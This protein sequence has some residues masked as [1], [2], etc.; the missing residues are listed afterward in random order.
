MSQDHHFLPRPRPR[1]PDSSQG[2]SRRSSGGHVGALASAAVAVF[3]AA[4]AAAVLLTVGIRPQ[5]LT[6]LY[7]GGRGG[8]FPCGGPSG[9]GRFSSP[10]RSARS[11]APRL[12]SPSTAATSPRAP[13]A[14]PHPDHDQDLRGGRG[15][16]A[17]RGGHPRD[18]P[19]WP[20]GHLGGANPGRY[21]RR[22]RGDG[23]RV[24]GGQ[25]HAIGLGPALG[26]LLDTFGVRT[27]LVPSIVVLL[28]RW[29][30]WPSRPGKQPARRVMSRRQLPRQGISFAGTTED[31]D[32]P[33]A[34]PGQRRVR[35]FLAWRNPARPIKGTWIAGRLRANHLGR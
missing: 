7:A 12:P 28:G 16:A 34:R 26:V 11:A 8:L 5:P 6:P 1:P 20:H 17:A 15:A 35:R 14:R 22:D 23:R 24:M 3:A 13:P 18:Q 30:W 2:A 29:N 32:C 4:V 10:G 33:E 31:P 25:L 19:H 21:F 27:L 9:G